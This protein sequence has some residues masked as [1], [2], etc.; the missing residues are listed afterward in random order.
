MEAN[1]KMNMK[2]RL[3]AFSF[4]TLG[5]ANFA[6]AAGGPLSI[7]SR[8]N[9]DNQGIWKR[10]NQKTLQALVIGGEIAGALWEGSDTR[11]G[12]TFWQSIDASLV[13]GAGY[14]VLNNTLRRERPGQTDNPNQWFKSGGH[15]FPS[16]EVTASV[17][18]SHRSSSNIVAIIRQCTRW[19]CCL[20]MMLKRE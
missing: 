4:A 5:C 1:M 15:S 17:L 2:V 10:S 18:P 6:L 13:S 14:L 8:L 3:A 7:D 19:N 11:L 20:Y 9:Y 12:K 16:G